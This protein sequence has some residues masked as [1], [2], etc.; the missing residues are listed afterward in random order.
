MNAFQ[1]VRT[2]PSIS[3]R[4]ILCCFSAGEIER[5]WE[6]A[7]LTSIARLK[8]DWVAP[9][10]SEHEWLCLLEDL[11]PEVILGAWSLPRIPDTFLENNEGF[12]YLCYFAGSVRGK[13]SRRFI[14][15]GGLV[16]NWGEIAARTVAECTL[17][18]VLT[19]LRRV[20]QYALEMHVERVWSQLREPFPSSLAGKSIGVHGFGAVARHLHHLLA[21]FNCRVEYWSQD[22]PPEVYIKHGARRAS[23]LESLFSDNDI[24][25]EAEALT[26]KTFRS[27][28]VD[29][30]CRIKPGGVF[31]NVG[32]G[33]VL[34]PGGIEAL[35]KRGDVAIGLDVYDQEPLHTDNPMRG[36]KHVT[37]LPHTAGPTLDQYP[38]IRRQSLDYLKRY[39]AGNPVPH[40]ILPESYDRMT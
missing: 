23:S 28:T 39:L 16:T 32:R 1:K 36:M 35:A 40:P 9:P 33:E 5:F 7:R 20:T 31:V 10:P 26:P 30:L 19:T 4:V 13:I 25:I 2:I 34:A 27:V 8:I 11:R 29:T 21:P 18:L 6:G 14:E 12:R 38:E 3:Q 15:H 24:V 17:M 22:V 37:L